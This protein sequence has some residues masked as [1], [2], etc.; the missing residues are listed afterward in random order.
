MSELD[1]R[2][3]LDLEIMK[4]DNSIYLVFLALLLSVSCSHQLPYFT[5]RLTS[6]LPVPRKASAIGDYSLGCLQGAQTFLG[7]EKGIVISQIKRGRYWG[8]PDLIKLLTNAGEEFYKS[9][10]VIIIGDLSQSR[11]GPTLSGHNSHQTGL[12]VDVWF[13]VLQNKNQ[14][15]FREL[16]T[17]DMK[18]TDK[19]GEDQ[20]KL[21][22]FFTDDKRVE[23]IFINPLFKRNICNNQGP[24][25]LSKDEQH[26]LRA[27]WGHDD[28]IH[29]R[30]NCPLD[31]PLCLSQKPIP[32]GDGCGE[33]LSWWFT[34]EAK[35][36]SDPSYDELKSIYLD[37]VK[38]LPEECSFYKETI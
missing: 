9:N 18:P 10:R 23:R 29:V 19:L 38:K 31:S 27:W 33:E 14:L 16:E 8:H 34:D 17:E 3:S 30:L 20:I 35:E 4:I 15:S 1:K 11:G 24:L 28:H 6:R 26:K 7:N 21:L 32:E 22:K 12:D 13:K 36:E 2:N 37:K 25:K 5:S